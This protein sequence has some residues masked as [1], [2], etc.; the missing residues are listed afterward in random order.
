MEE[1]IKELETK[2]VELNLTIQ[3]LQDRVQKLE[4]SEVSTGVYLDGV[5]EYAKDYIN[6]EGE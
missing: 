3:S 6:K 5:P 4:D 2:L 1:K